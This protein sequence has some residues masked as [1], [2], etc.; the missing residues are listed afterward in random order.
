MKTSNECDILVVF[1]NK[2]YKIT[3][4]KNGSVSKMVEEL[5]KSFSL[6]N[7]L[8]E[9]YFKEKKLNIHQNLSL[10]KL[11]GKIDKNNLPCFYIEKKNQILTSIGKSL[12]NNNSKDNI[13]DSKNLN[14]RNN[15]QIRNNVKCN[16]I[17]LTKNNTNRNNL[18]RINK[19]N[20]SKINEPINLRKKINPL[21]I[22]SDS[23]KNIGF[24]NKIQN[25][26]NNQKLMNDFY[27][28]QYYIRN[29]SPYI[30]E[31]EQRLLNE[32]E[33]KKH[34]LNQKDFILS[35]GHYSIKPNY[36]ENYVQMT[37]SENPLNHK[38]REE[39]KEKWITKKGFINA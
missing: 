29:S 20:T 21:P 12:T 30:S 36:I 33:N 31:E 15:K 27:S 2:T 34:F 13:Y 19:S 1:D 7:K 9:I 11:I 23:E 28:Q 5:F 35:V 26:K 4:D 16:T 3:I 10:S 22:N 18:R 37:P 25:I 32:K 6:D 38:F 14:I 39:K 17:K 24:K 8:Y